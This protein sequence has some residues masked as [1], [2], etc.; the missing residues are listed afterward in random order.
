MS[1]TASASA[2]PTKTATTATTTPPLPTPTKK[3]VD[4]KTWHGDYNIK[5][6][7]HPING[8]YIVA[9]N[10]MEE[11]TVILHDLPYVW[12]VDTTAKNFV[13]QQC[14]L[15]VPLT[16]QQSEDEPEYFV[17]CERCNY[18]GYCSDECRQLD[19]LQHNL[20]CAIFEHFDTNEYTDSLI[21][22]VKL[23]VRT[24]S[25]KWLELSLNEQDSPYSKYKVKTAIPQE[26]GLRYRDYEQLVS[27][28]NS[29]CPTL[30]ESLL[31]WICNKVMILAKRYTGRKEDEIDL[32]NVIL[33]NRCNAFYI[34]GRPKAG[35]NGE[36]RG[37]GVYCLEDEA[38][39]TNTTN[40]ED[41]PVSL[42][43]STEEN[44][45][46]TTQSQISQS[47]QSQSQ[48]QTSSSESQINATP[49]TVITD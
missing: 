24:L 8:R 48:S 33:R 18:V 17:M 29:F 13:C 42:V 36:S 12:A 3:K 11:S 9:T 1:T 5:V 34:Q 38:L 2:S 4:Y 47:S 21:S 10:D 15:E 20:E 39:D 44:Q 46:Q 37:C 27:N 32:L 22:E 26:N 43:K 23:L 25:R 30:K 40:T 16:S 14:F 45:S 28:I 41:T 49:D 31:H 35:G 6:M 7:S 19:A